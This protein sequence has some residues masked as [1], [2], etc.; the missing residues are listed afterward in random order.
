MRTGDCNLPSATATAETATTTTGATLG[1]LVNADSATVEPAR[2]LESGVPLY[3]P[4]NILN[5][6]HGGD[7]SLGIGLLAIPNETEATAATSVTVLDDDLPD[8]RDQSDC[9]GIES[10]SKL[11]YSLLDGAELLELLTKSVLISV[12][13]KAT[14]AGALAM[15]S[16]G[17]VGGGRREHELTQ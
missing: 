17:A 10:G 16:S 8:I 3:A 4:E 13:C 6:V 1:S 2:Q 15:D 11:T 9:S 14:T 5:V 7:G 12:P